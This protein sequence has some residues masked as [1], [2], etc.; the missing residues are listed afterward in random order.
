MTAGVRDLGGGL[1]TWTAR[2]PEWHPGE[3]GALV[4]S[5]AAHSGD[6]TLLIDPL[7]L[8]DETWEELD[9][10]VTGPVDTV[11]TI[12][13]HVRSA[14][15]AQSRYGG[16]IFGPAAVAKRLRSIR[17]FR[18]FAAGD[19]LPFGA[20]AHPV[21]NPRRQETPLELPEVSALVFGDAVVE[22]G[23]ELKVWVQAPLT[24]KRLKW[25]WTRFRP[26]VE[27]LA[28]L[29]VERVLVT[30]GEPVMEHGSQELSA[31]LDRPWYH[32]PV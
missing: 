5:Y 1:W 2:H 28:Q 30:H 17:S 13:Y 11:I 19:T 9:G 3:F 26:S 29:G 6:H 31:A 32:R 25:Y 24:E 18:P 8:S 20:I 16:S 4:R 10:I 12:G 23:G 7:V 21:G 22:A 15:A 14:E 27:P